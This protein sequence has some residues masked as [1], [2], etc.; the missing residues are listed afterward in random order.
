MANPQKGLINSV[1]S[2]ISGKKNEGGLRTQSHFVKSGQSLS[3]LG[4]ADKIIPLIT[5]I[6]VVFNGVKGLEKTIQ[7]VIGQSY[8]NVEYIVIDGGSSDGT[9]DIIGKYESKIDY[10]ISEKDSGIYDAMNKGVGFARGNYI[11]II[12]AGDWYED[13]AISSVVNTFLRTNAD[14]VYGDV[15]L[16]DA[17]TT[18]T[19]KRYSRSDLMPKTMSS[20]SHPSTFIK[21]TIY[22]MRPF[23]TQLRIAAD[24][25][26]FL[27]LYVGGY[28][29][30]HCGVTV[31]HILSG[32]VSSSFKTQ[33]EVFKVHRKYYGIFHSTRHYFTSALRYYFYETRR[34]ILIRLLPPAWFA[35]LRAKWLRYKH[36]KMY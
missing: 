23:N 5:V 31:A 21:N 33:K 3:A 25:D 34:G 19:Y 24:Y 13:G 17:E 27:G 14:V 22:Q 8:P 35:A 10:W 15:E 28:L 6:T 30:A 2:P 16:V 4:E 36:Q 20:I 18:V 11:G 26:L 29:F 1:R 7:S 9:L 32:G 12:G